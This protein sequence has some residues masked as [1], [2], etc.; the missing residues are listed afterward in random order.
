[1]KRVVVSAAWAA[2]CFQTIALLS[3]CGGAPAHSV[4]GGS[5]LAI[6]SFTA[7]SA[8]IQA[9]TSTTLTAVFTGGTGVITPGGITVTSGMPASV[10]PTVT[11]TYTLTVTPATGAAITK[12]ASI[13]VVP[14]PQ[15]ASFTAGSNSIAYGGSTTLTA[16]FTGGTGVI[17]PGASGGA[18]GSIPVTSTTPATVNPATT[19]VYTLTVTSPAGVAITQQLT[20]TV[21]SSVSVC[22]SPSCSGPAIS[23]LLD[24]MNLAMWYDDVD[25]ASSILSAFQAAGVKSVRWPGGSNSDLY[26]W[27]TNSG[28]DSLYT[29]ADD[30][31]AE[32]E[33]KIV[34][35]GGLDLAVTANYGTNTDCNGGGEPTEAA[36]WA[37]AAVSDGTPIH[38]MTVGNEVYGSW[39]TDDHAVPHDPATYASAVSGANGY[40]DLIKAQSPNT[41]VGVVV[42]GGCTSANGCTNGWDSTVLS[43][44]K[45]YYDFVEYHYY[46]QNPGNESDTYLVQQ[47]ASDFTKDINAVKSELATVN[48][49]GTPIYVGE[50]G[51]VSSNP[52]AQ[53][54]SITQ[55]LYAGQVL[56]EAMND[57]I[58]RL[59]WWIGFGN[60]NGNQGNDSS[61]LYSW[62]SFGAYN[63]FSDGPGDVAYPNNSPCNYGASIGAMSPTAEAFNLFQNVAVNGEFPQQT[64]ITGDNT[65]V[66][67]YAATHGTGTALMLFNVN[68]TSP[69]TIT[70]A[71]G[72]QASSTD[73]KVTTYDK[74]IYDYTNTACALDPD[75]TYDP[76]HDYS[77]IDWA[78]PTTSDLGQQSLPLTLTLPPWSM[79]V[80]IVA[81]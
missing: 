38:Y 52:G 8:T 7:G 18:T 59:T 50:I 19:T 80:V 77:T 42:D 26:H 1:M 20:V 62:Q 27:A 74:Q 68:Q 10:S 3:G 51:S 45:G 48:E 73:V 31:F 81:Q 13:T 4:G 41:L 24:G 56:G 54:W 65:D 37:A 66:R 15:I 53:S 76:S 21:T 69:V 70:V 6:I 49:S 61:S 30:D 64:T 33:R 75:C 5:T 9:G 16:D 28:C 36:A 44:D 55:G 67:A 29:V 79:N 34:Q 63:V 23:D 35:A 72:S 43:S 40:Y 60:C 47:A 14:A 39:E 11:T 17:T 58:A 25:N 71:L 78:P 12:T 32:F 22:L 2:F 57:G 46:P